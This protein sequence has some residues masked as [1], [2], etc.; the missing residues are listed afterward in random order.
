MVNRQILVLLG[1]AVLVLVVGGTLFRKTNDKPKLSFT[2]G[3]LKTLEGKLSALNA[4]DLGGISAG[5]I[6]TFTQEELDQLGLKIDGLNAED[7]E[8]LPPS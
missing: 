8:G 2:E 1:I 5:S 4:E 3:D 7:L 6:T